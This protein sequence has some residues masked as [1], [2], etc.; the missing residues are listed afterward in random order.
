MTKVWKSTVEVYK[1]RVNLF[2][3]IYPIKE[4]FL[5]FEDDT[6][7]LLSGEQKKLWELESRGTSGKC[8]STS[9]KQNL[10]WQWGK[11]KK[12]PIFIIEPQKISAVEST[13]YLKNSG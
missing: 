12:D 10:S 8:P 11:V 3:D 5:P 6:A 7:M 2:T 4:G 1:R 9:R 13:R